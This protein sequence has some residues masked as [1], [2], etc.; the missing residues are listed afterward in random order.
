M[1]ERLDEALALSGPVPVYG[2]TG[3]QGT[4]KSTLAADMVR[5]GRAR[6]L[7]VVALSVDDFYLGRRER[8][9][10][11]RC[12]HPLLATRGPPGSHDLDLACEVLDGLRAGARVR[13]PR[14]DKI[15]DRRLPPS[16]WPLSPP[17]PALVVF[18]G[19][20]HKVP[21]EDDAALAEPLNALERLEDP[22][23]SWRR[24]C[25]D[26]LGRYA[27]LW[28][29]LDWLTW[30]RGPGFEV[31]PRWRWQQ[32]RTLQAAHPGRRAMTRP[33]VERFVLFFER[34]SRQ[35]MRTLPALADRTIALDAER[36]PLS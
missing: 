7:N 4:G 23:G 5:T 2:L 12:V 36:R 6:G 18:E 27:R 20:F 19:W 31:V 35:A 10:L 3:L 15:A 24:Y 34:V 33:E 29:R 13:L 32:E 14:F 11:G 30:L 21:P 9:A 25:N 17:S 8:L 28:A 26:A 1:A 22:D 16:R